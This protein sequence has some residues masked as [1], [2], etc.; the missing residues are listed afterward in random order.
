MCNCECVTKYHNV[1][2]L[3]FVNCTLN[4]FCCLATWGHFYPFFDLIHRSIQG[5]P[6]EVT[7]SSQGWQTTITPLEWPS[8]LTHYLHLVKLCKEAGVQHRHRQNMQTPHRNA[9]T[10]ESNPG[11]SCCEATAPHSCIIVPINI[12]SFLCRI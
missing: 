3:F 6:G 12:K 10:W 4:V 5:H 1:I 8:N 2:G 9:L 11:P 7:S